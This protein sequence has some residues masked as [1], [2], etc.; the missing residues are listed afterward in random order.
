MA[1]AKK[2]VENTNAL[3]TMEIATFAWIA[4]VDRTAYTNTQLVKA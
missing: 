4:A 3:M 1:N 2:S